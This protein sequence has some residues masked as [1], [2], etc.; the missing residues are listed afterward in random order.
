[1][2]FDKHFFFPRLDETLNDQEAVSNIRLCYLY[3]LHAQLLT[4]RT[5]NEAE[6]VLKN[7]LQVN[8]VH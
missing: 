1:V 8:D 3:A 5:Q 2:S 6:T 7:L 4:T